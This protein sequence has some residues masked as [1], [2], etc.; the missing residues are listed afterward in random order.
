MKGIREI[1]HRIKSVKNT[2]Q[3]TR[4][5]Q[6]VAASKMKKAQ[7]AALAGRPYSLLMAEILQSLIDNVERIEHPFFQERPVECRG[8]LIISTDKGL[9]GAL[10]TNLMRHLSDIQGPTRFITMGRKAAQFLARSG[11]DVWADFS[12]TDQASFSEVRP[13]AEMLIR[14]YLEGKIDRVDVLYTRFI[15]TLKQEVVLAPLLPLSG[16]ESSL[17]MLKKR[18]GKNPHDRIEDDRP[19]CFEPNPQALIEALPELFIKQE[20]YQ[21]TLEAKASEH[22]A[23]MVAMKSATDNAKALVEDLTLEYNKARQAAITQEILE[24]AASTSNVSI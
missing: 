14:S 23:R 10:N 19:I 9:C 20:I 18:A 21:M 17:E 7:S 13:A 15:N 24:I 5:M 2:A 4:A 11:K 12:I 16:L 22:S 1:K 6:L 3:I 8:V